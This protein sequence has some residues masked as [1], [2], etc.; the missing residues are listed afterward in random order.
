LIWSGLIDMYFGLC[1]GPLPYRSL[2]FH[3]ET[4]DVERLQPVGTINYPND[5]A[6][7]RTTEF[8]HLTGQVHTQLTIAYEYPRAT[9]E[10]FYP[11]P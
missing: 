10:A 7:T 5:H 11:V 3:F 4:H 2:K 6:Y 8:K 1:F 9:G